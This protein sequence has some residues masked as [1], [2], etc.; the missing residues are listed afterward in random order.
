ML[1]NFTN[2]NVN[3]LSGSDEQG[4][5]GILDRQTAY[6]EPGGAHIRPDINSHWASAMADTI[7]VLGCSCIWCRRTSELDEDSEVERGQPSQSSH[8]RICSRKVRNS[9]MATTSGVLEVLYPLSY[10]STPPALDPEA[11]PPAYELPPPPNNPRVQSPPLSHW[12]GRD[13]VPF[14]PRLSQLTP[15]GTPIPSTEPV[16]SYHLSNT[17]DVAVPSAQSYRRPSR[18]IARQP[19]TGFGLEFRTGADNVELPAYSRFDSSWPRF[20]A[21][22][23]TLGPYPHISILSP[24][25]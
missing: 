3:S 24:V 4:D 11:S 10:L 20:P 5:D 6:I 8:P 7:K 22:S 18:H 15:E 13:F 17:P 16:S 19:I 23:D 21:A 25:I 12:E 14:T 1:E 2:Q 9:P